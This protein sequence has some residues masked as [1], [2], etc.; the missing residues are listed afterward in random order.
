MCEYQEDSSTINMRSE[1]WWV[2]EVNM[3]NCYNIVQYD[4]QG[5]LHIW[6]AS[7]IVHTLNSLQLV[8]T[9][10]KLLRVHILE[11]RLVPCLQYKLVDVFAFLHEDTNI[12]AVFLAR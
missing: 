4:P 7:D 5:Y 12:F 11:G 1:V 6:Y 2:H 9:A 10:S 3:S 8:V